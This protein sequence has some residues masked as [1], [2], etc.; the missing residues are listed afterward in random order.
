[1]RERPIG[2]FSTESLGLAIF[3]GADLVD[4]DAEPGVVIM[5]TDSDTEISSGNSTREDTGLYV[6]SLSPSDTADKGNFRATWTY[7]VGGL[8]RIFEDDFKVT[9]PMP[10]WDRL[11]YAERD[12][13]ANIYHKVSDAFDSREGG[14]YLWELYQTQWNAYETIARLMSTDAVSYINYTFQPAFIPPY[15]VG[16]GAS[17]AFPEQWSGL[18]ERATYV[19]FL[20]HISRSYIEIPVPQ[21]VTTARLDRTGYRREW[22]AEA[23]EEKKIM[24]QMLRMFKRKFLVGTSRAIMMGG[25]SIPFR[26]MSPARPHWMYSIS[27]L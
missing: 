21:G 19:E 10:F 25:G 17:K 27:Y 22:K 11:T 6:Y 24:D 5:D 9:D 15:Q 23:D 16:T 26:W 7:E 13:V 12:V 3:S 1:M 20:K 8:D 18:L 4:A 14:P 2:R